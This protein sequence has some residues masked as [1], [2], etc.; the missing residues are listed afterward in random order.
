MAD[1]RKDCVLVNSRY[2]HREI[3]VWLPFVWFAVAV[4]FDRLLWWLFGIFSPEVILIGT[5]LFEFSLVNAFFPEF[6]VSIDRKPALKKWH[7][8][9]F[10]ILFLVASFALAELYARTVHGNGL[11]GN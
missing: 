2:R 10:V 7:K 9:G 4:L 6:L 8:T 3:S 1:F 11:I 5:M